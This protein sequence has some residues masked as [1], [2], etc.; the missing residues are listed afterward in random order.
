MQNR[1][2]KRSVK[3]QVK[4]SCY[5]RIHI[6]SGMWEF[7]KVNAMRFNCKS[8]GYKG[9]QDLNPVTAKYR[10][11]YVG[12]W[13]KAKYSN[14]E[15]EIE[16][17]EPPKIEKKSDQIEIPEMIEKPKTTRRTRKKKEDE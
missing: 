9:Q 12:E 2:R 14:V 6:P 1:L 3:R 15:D 11:E 5:R 13:D 10:F 7:I 16:A 8:N 4:D 17:V